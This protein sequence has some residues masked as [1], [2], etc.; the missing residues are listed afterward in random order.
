MNAGRDVNGDSKAQ[1]E[2]PGSKSQN[3]VL[4]LAFSN[5]SIFNVRMNSIFYRHLLAKNQNKML[6]KPF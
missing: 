4:V 5:A 1:Q 6:V 2:T 3:G